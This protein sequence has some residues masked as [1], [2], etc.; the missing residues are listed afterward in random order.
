MVED[1]FLVGVGVDILGVELGVEVGV[2]LQRV[3]VVGLEQVRPGQRLALLLALLEQGLRTD[4]LGV[5]ERGVPVVH[6]DVVLVVGCR[7]VFH[8]PE[9]VERAADFGG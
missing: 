4:D 1:E 3:R 7:D 2:H 6:E 8:W 5:R 9:G